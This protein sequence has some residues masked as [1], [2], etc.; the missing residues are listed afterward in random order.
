MI[1]IILYIILAISSIAILIS[2]IVILITT[3]SLFMYERK[4]KNRK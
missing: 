4:K 1:S 2:S 3:V